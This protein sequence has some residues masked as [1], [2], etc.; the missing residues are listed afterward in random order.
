MHLGY[1]YFDLTDAELG[2][3][4]LQKD[5]GEGALEENE[6]AF[7]R[8]EGEVRDC[9][10]YKN[11]ELL[12]V[13]YDQIDNGYSGPIKPRNIEQRCAFSMLQDD[14]VPVKVLTGP[15]GSGKDF[16]MVNVALDKI[17]RGIYSKLIYVRN[18]IEV[19]D[20]VALGSLPG[21]EFDKLLPFAMPLADHVGGVQGLEGMIGRETIEVQHLGFIR[22]RDFKRSIIL[23][24][25]AE[26]LT[27]PHVQLLLGRVG[28][29]SALWLNGDHKQ[30]DKEIFRAN[31]G[32]KM[33]TDR[34]T[35]NRLFGYVHLTKSERSEV[36]RLA[37]LLD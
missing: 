34:L 26:N 9:Y 15:Y 7:I 11:G 30:T 36:S 27:V 35:G 28:E 32:L 21:S 37:D 1:K 25:E 3:F 31:S 16:L 17:R 8:Y 18:N 29:G 19:K 14:A 12:P 4:Y 24:S 5:L 13:K 23:C 2:R 33:I 22:G 10:C 6:F 20:T